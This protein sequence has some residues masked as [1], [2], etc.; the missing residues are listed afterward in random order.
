LISDTHRIV[1]VSVY[2]LFKQHLLYFQCLYTTVV[3]E[4]CKTSYSAT[5][6]LVEKLSIVVEMACEIGAG[7]GDRGISTVVL[8]LRLEL[9]HLPS[10]IGNDIRVENVVGI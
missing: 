10:V 5:E 8:C 2:P 4:I 9:S 3:E 6:K 7:I 1:G